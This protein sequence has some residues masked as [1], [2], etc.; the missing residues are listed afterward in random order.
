[1]RSVLIVDDHAVFRQAAR[2]ALEADGWRVVGEAA[3]GAAALAAVPELE[4]DVLLL[5]V[6]LPD[7]SGLELARTIHAAH[8]ELMVVL[9]STHDSGDFRQLARDAGALGFLAKAELSGPALGELL[10]GRA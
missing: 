4:P 6:Y 7:A 9:V 2:R 8:P 1:M 5:D 3:D 10:S